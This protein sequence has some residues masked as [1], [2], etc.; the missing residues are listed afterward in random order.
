MTNC[1][2][3][4]LSSVFSSLLFRFSKDTDQGASVPLSLSSLQCS[5]LLE[6]STPAA[7]GTGALCRWLTLS[8]LEVVLGSDTTVLPGFNAKLLPGRLKSAY[9]TLQSSSA[10]L[11]W[12]VVPAPNWCRLPVVVMCA[13][14]RVLGRCAPLY[15]DLSSTSGLGSSPARVQ[16]TLAAVEPLSNTVEALSV[17]D[18]RAIQ[19]MLDSQS[20]PLSNKKQHFVGVE[21]QRAS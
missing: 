17:A 8:E 5:S 9:G 18:Q 19:N 1:L 13:G 20:W 21:S 3:F 6:Q 14:A 11:L 2:F 15:L 4:W 10:A 16:W 7:A 12:A